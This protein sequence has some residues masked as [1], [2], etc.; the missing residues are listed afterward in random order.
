LLTVPGE[1][2]RL[3]S[4]EVALTDTGRRHTVRFSVAG[5]HLDASLPGGADLRLTRV[6]GADVDVQFVRVVKP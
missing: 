2:G 6:R 1:A 3:R 4:P 5:S